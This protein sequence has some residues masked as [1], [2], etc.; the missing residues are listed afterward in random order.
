MD[1]LDM[2]LFAFVSYVNL[3]RHAHSIDGLTINDGYEWYNYMWQT[4][5]KNSDTGR[6]INMR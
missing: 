6:K 4:W 2:N 5:L 3:N 1:K